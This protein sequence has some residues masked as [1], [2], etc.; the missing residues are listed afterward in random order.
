MQF[1][2]HESRGRLFEGRKWTRRGDRGWERAVEGEKEQSVM[3]YVYER[4]IV[5]PS[6]CV[7]SFNK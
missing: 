6:L 7:L 4:A 5:Q 2:R 1:V 3:T